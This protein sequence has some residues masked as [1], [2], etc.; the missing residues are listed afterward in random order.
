[1]GVLRRVSGL[2]GALLALALVSAPRAAADT[3]AFTWADA[4]ITAPV[5]MATDTDH[6][7]YWTTN[8]AAA[9]TSTTVYAVGSEGK[10]L[11][12]ISYLRATTGPLAVAYDA[13]RVFVLD[14]G[15]AATAVRVSYITL[16]SVIVDGTVSYKSWDL[17]FPEAGQTAAALIVAPN[18]Q[19]YVVAQTGR[20]YKAPATLAT[21]GTNKLTKVS[22]GAGAVTGGYYDKRQKSVVLRTA[23]SI[24]VA[25]PTTFATVSTVPAPAQTGGRGVAAAIDGASYLLTANGNGNAV[26]SV[27]LTASSASPSASLAPSGS[28]SAVPATQPAAA[29]AISGPE[30]SQLVMYVALGAAALLGLVTAV[31]ALVRR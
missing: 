25:D 9:K 8:A 31:I 24:V 21:S 12:A 27:P 23:T 20:V 1:M 28:A 2:V 11:A 7:M 10:V 3:V 26:L 16:S 15:T 29:A 18:T 13:N 30:A 4:R 19:L 22:D 5:G 14:K 6:N 17:T